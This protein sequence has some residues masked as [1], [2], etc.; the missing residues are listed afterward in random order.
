MKLIELIDEKE[1]TEGVFGALA[2]G[3]TY[4]IKPTQSAATVAQNMPKM[5][6]KSTGDATKAGIRQARSAFGPSNASWFNKYIRNHMVG[7]NVKAFTLARAEIQRGIVNIIGNQALNIF[8]AIGIVDALIDYLAAMKVLDETRPPDYEAQRTRLRGIF[9]AQILAPGIGMGISK[10]VTFLPK[11]IGLGLRTVGGKTIGTAGIRLNT[12][13]DIV[14]KIGAAGLTTILMT[15]KGKELLVNWFGGIVDGLGM[16]S[17]PFMSLWNFIYSN[18]QLAGVVPDVGPAQ[19]KAEKDKA[20]QA[21]EPGA[22]DPAQ[23]G[24]SAPSAS[25]LSGG[26]IDDIALKMLTKQLG[27]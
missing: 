1:L 18:L 26:S 23:S 25:D 11:M 12:A 13:L 20:G 10:I 4:G 8:I 24:T 27:L 2:R 6:Y 16:A 19:K 21:V 3:L 9:F 5:N 17:A 15:D 7:Q 22:A 14:E